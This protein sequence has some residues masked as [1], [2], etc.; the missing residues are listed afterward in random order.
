MGRPEEVQM[1][2]IVAR[3][4]QVTVPGPVPGWQVI[5]TLSL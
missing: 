5:I 1:M 3:G 2:D 4:R